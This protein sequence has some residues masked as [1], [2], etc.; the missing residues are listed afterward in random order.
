M[1]TIKDLLSNGIDINTAKRMISNYS[2]RINTMSGI[3]KITDINYDFSIKG[4]D[5]TLQCT[6]CGKIIHRT[7]V[8]GKNKWSE[9]IKRCDCQK[10]EREERKRW[11]I[12]KSEKIKKTAIV[13]RVGEIFGDYEIISADD[14]DE[15][16]KYTMRCI[17]CGAE[18]IILAN[19]FG[20]RKN[21]HCTK[22]YVCPVKYD[23][24]YIGAKNNFLTVVGLSRFENGHRAFVCQCDCGNIKKIEPTMWE[25]GYVKTC[26]CHINIDYLEHTEELDRLRRIYSCMKQRCYNANA[27]AYENYGARGV[28]I[29]QEWLDNRDCFIEWALNNGYANDLSIDR[30]NVNGNYEPSNCR[31]ADDFV[32]ARNKRPYCEC[33]QRKLKEYTINGIT[34]PVTEWYVIY[35]T[36]Q[37]AIAYRMKTLGMTFEQ[38]LTTPKMASGRP[39]KEVL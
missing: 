20:Q 3:Y 26:G 7:M 23:E 36:S 22:H 13:N 2:N 37:P 28:E 31:W 35:E 25:K 6:N 18:K 30:I 38:A 39:R 14:I 33:K 16:P 24:S 5:V 21:F 9:L 29:C 34:R 19:S 4:R 32:Q 17:E 1:N 11:E 10:E 12:E 8:H 27:P 15:K